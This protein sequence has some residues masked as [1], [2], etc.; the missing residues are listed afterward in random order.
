VLVCADFDA[1]SL[2][3]LREFADVEY[4]PFREKLRL[5]SGDLLVQE[6]ADY[7]VFVTEI[8]LVD[9]AALAQLP[10][11][12]VVGACR[13]DAV[14]VD[15]AACSAYGIPVVHAPGRNA[16]AVADLAIAFL[17]MLARKF[18]A[19]GSFLRGGDIAAGDMG[20]ARGAGTLRLEGKDYQVE[21]ADI[22]DFRFNV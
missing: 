7:D 17:L 2:A 18:P 21:D 1:S 13:G 22:I 11:L 4:A 16:D 5:L 6:L 12:R 8:D 19:A 10:K 9:A 15:V 14:N 20:N 3:S